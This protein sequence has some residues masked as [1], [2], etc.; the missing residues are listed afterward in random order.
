MPE[1]TPIS[2][3]VLQPFLIF[4]FALFGSLLGSFSNV[5]IL[6]MAEGRSV[7]FPPSSC[8]YCHHQLSPLDLI[9]IFGWLFLRGKCRYCGAPI[10]CQYPLVE[11]AAALL[12]GSAFARFGLHAEF[13]ATAAWSLLWL[14]VTI[15]H[16]R[17]ECGSA[18]PFLWPLAFRP[19]LACFVAPFAPV[20]W[21]VALGG[22]TITAA[23]IHT[24]HP[25]EKPL[26]W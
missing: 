7:V 6:R 5:V 19:A 8:P 12:V 15:M 11:T 21:A 16:V 4:F 23:L 9:P 24:R 22:G 14:V 17:R 3:D 18:Q 1:T 26:I 20:P 13:I 25:D 2:P 10:S